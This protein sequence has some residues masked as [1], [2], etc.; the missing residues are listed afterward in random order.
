M[1]TFRNR[2]LFTYNLFLVAL[3]IT[4]ISSCVKEEYEIVKPN[5]DGSIT[6]IC[7]GM[8]PTTKTVL[9][10]LTTH[11][12]AGVDKV[13]IFSDQ[14]RETA[15]GTPGV[16]N[17]PLT[18]QS[19]GERSQFH[20]SVFW[21]TGEHIFYS[22]YPYSEGSPD[23]TDV[24]VS[25][26]K[27]QTQ[28]A[29]NDVSHLSTLDFLVARPHTAKYPGN[30]A[31]EATVSLRYNHLF[32]ILEFQII[33]S[34]GSGAISK[35][36]LNGRAP[37]AFES[38]SINLAQEA[39]ASGAPYVIDNIINPSNSIVVSL[40]TAITPTS[41]YTT[42]PKVYMVVLPGTHTGNLRI[43]F[44]TAGI[45]YEVTKS[46][47]TFER[48]KKYIVKVDAALAEI[49]SIK[50]TELEPITI[51]G[52]TWAPLNAGYSED[53]KM[54][55]VYQWLRKY[56]FGLQAPF[57]ILAKNILNFD[58]DQVTAQ[59][60]Y[61][62]FFLAMAEIPNDWMPVKQ[63]EW[64]LS[65][66]F[67]PC[68]EGWGLPKIE[69]YSNLISYGSTYVTGLTGGV[70]GLAGRWIGPNHDNPDLRTTTALFFPLTGIIGNSIVSGSRGVQNNATYWSTSAGGTN[71]RDGVTLYFTSSVLPRSTILP[72]ANAVAVRCVKYK[73][74]IEN[75]IF[76]TIKPFNVKHNST[77]VGV[78]IEERGAYPIIEKGVVYNT[79]TTVDPTGNK[80]VAAPGETGE[81]IVEMTGLNPSAT[82]I[83]RSYVINSQ[84]QTFYGDQYRLV[85]TPNWDN[86]D[87]VTIA[88]V[89][90]A[91]VNMGYDSNLF[92]GLLFQW[93]RRYGQGYNTTETPALS[94]TGPTDI[95]VINAIGNKDK[96]YKPTTLPFD[97]TSS[98]SQASWVANVSPCPIGWRLP[99]AEEMTGLIAS[100]STWASSGIN[101]IPGRWFGGNHSGDKNGSVF[102]PAAG[103]RSYDTTAR[104]RDDLGAYWTMTTSGN[105]AQALLFTGTHLP[106]VTERY[107]GDGYSIRCVK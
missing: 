42:T 52:I 57:G 32:A 56:G 39:P 84:A 3:L 53:L 82:Y 48:G 41:N 96:F 36:K 93:S 95:G 15:G 101:G 8:Q 25:L 67:N 81:F 29:G 94:F 20:G 22:Y 18:A 106:Y 28:T 31:A 61:K 102:F 76:Y 77:K 85:T 88:G 55:E 24:P 5:E 10:G 63:T 4:G 73:P 72:R 79:G 9:N 59:E 1:D 37:L 17:I 75:P 107:R 54:G 2:Q 89:T 100:G 71:N 103:M 70:D 98:G 69:E 99:S 26:P 43:E 60:R 6:F 65:R 45:F 19:S 12:V 66:R 91:P 104:Q 86:L 78:F 21:G 58:L 11:W 62:N 33:R 46:D 27:E 105:M 92:Y 16:V 34:S 87:E 23:Y 74:I 35:V 38:G 97:C 49:A 51:D 83:V 68:P 64:N 47:I 14:A 13:G 50:G 40:G 7:D 80:R 30:S 44:E 90:W